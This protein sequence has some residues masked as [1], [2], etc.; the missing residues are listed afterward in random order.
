MT[1]GNVPFVLSAW[2]RKR[3]QIIGLISRNQT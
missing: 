2:T 3:R 1:P